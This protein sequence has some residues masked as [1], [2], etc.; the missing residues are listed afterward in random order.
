MENQLVLGDGERIKYI[1]V[2]MRRGEPHPRVILFIAK[3]DERPCKQVE[4]FLYTNELAAMFDEAMMPY[5]MDCLT[6][7]NGIGVQ[8]NLDYAAGSKWLGG[9]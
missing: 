7:K 9:K 5:A 3:G 6:T 1:L 2:E 4:T 8:Y